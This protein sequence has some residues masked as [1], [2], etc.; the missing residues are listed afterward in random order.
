MATTGANLVI[1]E[2]RITHPERVISETGHITKGALAEY[3][4][5]IAPLLLFH[6]PP[7]SPD[8]AGRAKA[9]PE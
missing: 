1:G 2:T 6:V 9:G 4:A 7:T 5:A 8:E 3:Y